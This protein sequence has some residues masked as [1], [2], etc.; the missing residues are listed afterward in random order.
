MV[1]GGAICTTVG[2]LSA[3][4]SL[5]VLMKPLEAHFGWHREDI[6]IA[7]SFFTAGLFLFGPWFGRLYDRFGVKRIAPVAVILMSATL[8][9][10]TLVRNSIWALYGAYFALGFFGAGTS[11]PAYARVVSTW[12][13]KG[14]GLALALTM[15]GPAIGATLLPLLLPK[16]IHSYGWRGGYF[17]LSMAAL[18]ALPLVV[19]VVHER[20]GGAGVI[21]VAASGIA[22]RQAVRTRQF[23]LLACGMFC[24]GLAIVGSTLHLMPM[25]TDRGASPGLAAYA[26][27]LSGIGIL[28]GR[29]VTGALVDRF[30]APAVAACL[31]S[32]PPIAFLL[33]HIIGVPFGPALGFMIGIATGAEADALGYLTSRYFGLRSYSEI[34]GWLFGAMML[35]GTASPIL[36]KKLY[37]YSGGYGSCLSVAGGLCLTAAVLFGF[38]GPYTVRLDSDPRAEA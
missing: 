9:G 7:S 6:A 23:W 4:Y 25:L 24:V 15:M 10:T 28:A 33:F 3:G 18:V 27:T 35:G 14:R 13:A 21:K 5:S 19:F 12:F 29:A 36:F 8:A 34:F 20:S 31:F 37:E 30:F 17:A 16:A 38:L 22:I 32:A 11:Y 1:L 26:L 2:V